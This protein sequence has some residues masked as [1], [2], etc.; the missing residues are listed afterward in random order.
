MNVF[1]MFFG[2]KTLR[3]WEDRFLPGKADPDAFMYIAPKKGEA[4]S[5]T[6][7]VERE[8]EELK[9][10]LRQI[11]MREWGFTKGEY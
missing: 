8:A 9:S 1:K 11:E 2:L 3:Q 10:L 6:K 4:G 5:V 7:C